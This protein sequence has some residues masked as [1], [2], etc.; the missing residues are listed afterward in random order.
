MKPAC[1]IGV[2]KQYFPKIKTQTEEFFK[3]ISSDP[4]LKFLWIGK[5]SK[6]S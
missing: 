6:I 5:I 1:G 3:L 4:I 2:E